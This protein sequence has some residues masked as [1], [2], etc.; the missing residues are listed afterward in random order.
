MIAGIRGRSEGENETIETNL[1]AARKA[2]AGT[3]VLASNESITAIIE[4]ARIPGSQPT[5]SWEDVQVL[6]DTGIEVWTTMNVQHIAERDALE[7]YLR[8]ARNLRIETQILAG[9]DVPRTEVEFARRS[10]VSQIFVARSQE[11][12][13]E[14]VLGRNCAEDI[15]RI[16]H[17]L[18][19]T[20]V[21]DR[22]RKQG[23]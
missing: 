17:D 7:N 8:F 14:R 15:V 5:K 20:V 19:V 3:E 1:E 9:Q 22:S 4:F 6:L 21:A 16:A 12:L 18:Q 2:G 10:Q 13:R 11:R 23:S